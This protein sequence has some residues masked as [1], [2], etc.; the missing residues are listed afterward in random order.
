MHSRGIQVV[1][2]INGPKILFQEYVFT[3][4][5]FIEQC[6]KKDIVYAKLYSEIAMKGVKRDII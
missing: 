4:N 1:S 6:H 3:F 5:L 2:I